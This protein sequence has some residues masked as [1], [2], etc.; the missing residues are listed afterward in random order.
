MKKLVRWPS[1]IAFAISALCMVLGAG[2]A[3]AEPSVE[4]AKVKLSDARDGT[5]DLAYT[6]SGDFEGW[7]YDLMIWASAG[8]GIKSAVL[9]T[10]DVAPGAV[11]K[12][13]NV[14]A[15]LGRAYPGISFF[16]TLKKVGVQLWEDGPIFAEC[17]IGATKPEDYGVP[18][19]APYRRR[20]WCT[21]RS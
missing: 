14:K 17:N 20:R 1:A 21:G 8:D 15:R 11:T 16:A 13:V 3:F 7:N 5:V 12:V 6:V 10:E 9:T 4:I 18:E 19:S 2:A